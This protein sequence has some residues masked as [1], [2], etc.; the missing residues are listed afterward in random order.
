MTLKINPQ[1]RE[2]TC[3]LSKN[4]YSSLKESIKNNG[5]WNGIIVNSDG[6][7]LDGHQRY[8]ICQE[9]NITPKTII[10]E[11][12]SPSH[13]RIFVG[14][15]ALAGKHL[16]PLQ[17]IKISQIIRPELEKIAKQNMSDGGKGLQT[18]ANLDT[19][20]ILAKK[21][22]VSHDTYSK[23]VHI[24][25]SKNEKLISDTLA[26]YKSINSAYRQI[27]MK[28]KNLI[29]QNIP[30]DK[31]DLIYLDP[32]WESKIGESRGSPAQHYNTMSDGMIAQL[33]LPMA[34]NCVVFCWS[35][36]SLLESTLSIIQS[37]GLQYRSQIVWDKQ[38]IGVGYWVRGCHETLLICTKGTVP[39][40][41]PSVLVPS[42]YHEKKTTHSTKP[43]YFYNIIEAYYPAR[44]K[45][46]MFARNNRGAG[47]L[48]EMN[49]RLHS[50]GLLLP[51]MSPHNER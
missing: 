41:D 38:T 17:R 10:K 12:E 31:F 42:I 32:P 7:I 2:I 34:E 37:W 36:S 43:D 30:D 5:L 44:K 39:V 40:P 51:H 33:Q 48:G 46:E 21:A 4:D 18:S 24:L 26:G 3:E 19:R 25:E 45:L 13:E 11:F 22:N 9:L 35:I 6:I 23:G 29:P 28:E 16:V 49:W 50:N 47:H 15:C 20:E 14:D 1:Y 27:H 8:N